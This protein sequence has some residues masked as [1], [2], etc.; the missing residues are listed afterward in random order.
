M[1]KDLMDDANPYPDGELTLQIVALPADTNQHGLIHG[2]WLAQF[3]Q[4][5]PKVSNS[6]S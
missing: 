5:N 4:I 6:G 1:I 2:G 3:G